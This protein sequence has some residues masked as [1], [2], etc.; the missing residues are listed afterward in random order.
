MKLT[1]F[2]PRASSISRADLADAMLAA[3]ANTALYR[4]AI[5][6]AR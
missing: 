5:A 1:L 6:I 4:H 3:V 2:G